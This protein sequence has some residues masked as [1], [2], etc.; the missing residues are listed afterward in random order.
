M[1]GSAP[2]KI[3]S[4]AAS[5]SREP[6]EEL[7]GRRGQRRSF[8]R[9]R[10]ST[11]LC[12]INGTKGIQWLPY[13]RKPPSLLNAPI[14]EISR[15]PLKRLDTQ[16]ILFY[17]RLSLRQL[18]IISAF[19]TFCKKFL[20]K[21]NSF[22]YLAPFIFL[23]VF[24]LFSRRRLRRRPRSLPRGQRPTRQSSLSFTLLQC[25]PA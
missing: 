10:K 23:G 25:P 20:Q 16:C 5:R 24:F 19:N 8:Y 4:T 21:N 17:W 14:P 1:T 6:R 15:I 11:C 7:L 9:L 12:A 22:K 3:K 13:K 18:H 2:K